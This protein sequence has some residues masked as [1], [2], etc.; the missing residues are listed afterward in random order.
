MEKVGRPRPRRGHG[1]TLDAADG[2]ARHAPCRARVRAAW[3][4]ADRG[5]NGRSFMIRKKVMPSSGKIRI[6]FTVRQ[7]DLLLNHTLADDSYAKRLRPR[8]SSSKLVGEYSIGD[9]EDMLGFLA[10]AAS[11]A[12][13]RRLEDELD[14]TYDKLEK[15]V[16][17][18]APGRL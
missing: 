14:A 16:A 11:H 13:T 7:R 5:E 8:E 4:A 3:P 12:E 10:E 9:L 2:P 17:R 18:Y 15:V 6:A 1:I